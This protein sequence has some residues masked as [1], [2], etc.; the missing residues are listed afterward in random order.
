MHLYH[1]R[2]GRSIVECSKRHAWSTG[3]K[4]Y[5]GR[6]GTGILYW[7]VI[8][9]FRDMKHCVIFLLISYR[10]FGQRGNATQ[11]CRTFKRYF[12]IISSALPVL[13]LRVYI[14]FYLL[15]FNFRMFLIFYP[16]INLLGIFIFDLLFPFSLFQKQV[17]L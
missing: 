2:C 3:D 5:R 6:Y 4:W 8:W 11:K 16:S 17:N 13:Y 12:P 9:W 14:Y 10:F 1:F 7:A 15:L